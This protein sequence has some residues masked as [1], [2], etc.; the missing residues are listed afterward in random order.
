MEIKLGTLTALYF[1]SY[2]VKTIF[3]IK[4]IQEAAK[5]GL[6]DLHM[7]CVIIMVLQV[8]T[9]NMKLKIKFCIQ[10]TIFN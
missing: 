10:A 5:F 1:V 8:M 2:L 9:L 6:P 4:T 3:E 7:T